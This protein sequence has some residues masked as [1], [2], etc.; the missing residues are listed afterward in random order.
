MYIGRY[1]MTMISKRDI[2][3]GFSSANATRESEACREPR[4]EF[5]DPLQQPCILSLSPHTADILTVHGT[6]TG[7]GQDAKIH[8]LHSKVQC[9][10]VWSSM[11]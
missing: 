11:I 6:L 8:R 5:C 2:C 10:T 3:Y 9:G 4:R 1:D 7:Q